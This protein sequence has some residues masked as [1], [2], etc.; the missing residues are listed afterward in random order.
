MRCSAEPESVRAGFLLDSE[1]EQS[2]RSV[3][4][5]LR[6][7]WAS[8]HRRFLRRRSPARKAGFLTDGLLMPQAETRYQTI[9]AMTH[10]RRIQDGR[11]LDLRQESL[12]QL[13]GQVVSIDLQPRRRLP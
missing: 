11:A 1:K 5:T 4:W 7:A 12:E 6:Q 10:H 8:E 2:R 13:Q 3:A 9:F